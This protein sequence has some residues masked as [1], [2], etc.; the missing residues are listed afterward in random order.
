[1]KLNYPV[2]GLSIILV[3]LIGGCVQ[4]ENFTPEGFDKKSNQSQVE[5]QEPVGEKGLGTLC[6]NE[7]ECGSFCLNN[8]GR[9]EDYCR[10]RGIELSKIIF[11]PGEE[12]IETKEMVKEGTDSQQFKY[13]N[14]LD[15]DW[16]H[17]QCKGNGTVNFGAAPMSPEDILVI[18]PMGDMIGG[19]V[20]PIDHMYIYPIKSRPV[21]IYAPANGNLVYVSTSGRF[22]GQKDFVQTYTL[23]FEHTCD[24]YTL[25]GLL[26]DVSPKIKEQ[27]GT[28]GEAGQKHVRIPVREGEVVGTILFGQS[29]D[30]NIL[31][32]QASPKQWVFPEHYTELGK[33]FIV[34][35][36][37]YYIEPVKSQLL[38]KNLR[39]ALPV[40]G[41]FDYDIDGTLSGSWFEEGTNWYEGLPNVKS[42]FG[43]YW[44]THIS[45]SSDPVDPNFFVIS[46]GNFDGEAMQFG[47]KGNS[48]KPE[49]VKSELVKYDLVEK[50]YVDSSGKEWG[51]GPAVKGLHVDHGREI[52]GVVLVQLLENKKLKFELFPGKTA[53]QVS[54]FTENAKIYER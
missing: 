8:R 37:D 42:S 1:M 53:S 50:G 29:L 39:S 3:A 49:E 46:L 6:S 5:I 27:I 24:F 40:G 7:E 15:K 48:P 25:F 20:T 36:F 23:M 41:K 52:K 13:K 18:I 2:L 43:E 4:Q 19:H 16:S 11:P 12:F 44:K 21:N 31:Y 34:D 51:F 28:M 22:V 33:K 38:G 14:I 10:G 30:Y 26:D 47:A 32:T 35:P 9:C 54:G 17:G 45:F